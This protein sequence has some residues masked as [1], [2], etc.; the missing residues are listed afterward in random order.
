M[1][2]NGRL[3]PDPERG[4]IVRWVFRRLPRVR[5]YG[6][7]AHEL[8]AAGHLNRLGNT[9]DG[10][11][12][13]TMIENRVYLGEMTHKGEHISGTH[14]PLVTSTMWRAA[15]KVAAEIRAGRYGQ[16]GAWQRHRKMA[17]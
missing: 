9:F 10:R 5:C 7:I 15:Q 2:V 13:K 16:M 1:R 11:T 6:T 4:P 8:N 12:V 14:E 17:P 3:A